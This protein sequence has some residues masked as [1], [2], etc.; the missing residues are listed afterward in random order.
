[1]DDLLLSLS[2]SGVGC[3]IGLSFVGAI[4][5]ADDIVLISPTPFAMRKLLSICDSFALEFDILFN[6]AKSKFLV[7]LAN[8]WRSLC[9][10]MNECNFNIGGNPIENVTSYPHLGHV[11]NS[12]FN[13]NDDIKHRRQQFIGQSNNVFC[14]FAKLDL[15]V[16]KLNCLKHSAVASMGVSYGI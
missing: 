14:F 10:S 8:K 9:T 4:A 11:I 5:Y 16:I 2:R 7:I 15:C 3:Y 6:A 12:S 1:M 13:D